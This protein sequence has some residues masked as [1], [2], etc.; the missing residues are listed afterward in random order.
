M[1]GKKETNRSSKTDTPLE[2]RNA[3]R[4][5]IQK[6]GKGCEKLC[7]KEVKIKGDRREYGKRRRQMRKKKLGDMWRGR[8]V[9]CD[10]N[11][12]LPV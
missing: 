4:G 7:S 10:T 9:T 1:E 6:D 2:N 11:I 3:K 12:W 8:G 5:P